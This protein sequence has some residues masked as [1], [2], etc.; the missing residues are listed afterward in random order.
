[1]TRLM[2]RPPITDIDTQ[3]PEVCHVEHV[4]QLFGVCER[5]ITRAVQAGGFQPAPMPEIGA[6]EKRRHY[7]WSREALRHFVRGG[8][9]VFVHESITKSRKFFGSAQA[10]MVSR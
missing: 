10:R 1:M 9:L 4:A 8:Y 3:L 2:N 6:S 5:T 7:R